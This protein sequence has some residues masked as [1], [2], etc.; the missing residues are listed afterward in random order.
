MLC[1]RINIW[2]LLM[3]LDGAYRTMD[4]VGSTPSLG[5]AYEH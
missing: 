2:L 3:D 1:R 5:K 4:V